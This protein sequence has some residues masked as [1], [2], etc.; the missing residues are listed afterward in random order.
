MVRRLALLVVLLAAALPPAAAHAFRLPDPLGPIRGNP[1]EALA[2]VAPDPETYD[3]ATRCDARPKPGVVAFARWL[4]AWGHGAY[5]GSYR[6]ER[7]GKDSASLH[8]ENRAIDWRLDTRSPA[9]R[10]AARTLIAVLLAP[11][12]AGTPR[13]LARRMG[14][15]ELIW[16]CSY[17]SAGMA[18]FRPYGPCRDR[19]VDRTTAHRDHLHV[20]FSKAGAAGRTTFWLAAR[21]SA[22]S[23][24]R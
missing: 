4:Q 21:L 11:D 5:W 1:A 18:D 24:R 16:D 9:D 7:W 6:C 13:A 15:E 20:G 14:V 17:W 22:R 19:G 3:P 23:R 10:A 2:A 12:R 8:A